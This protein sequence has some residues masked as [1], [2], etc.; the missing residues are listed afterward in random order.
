MSEMP[1]NWPGKGLESGLRPEHLYP[2]CT[3]H[4]LPFFPSFI[5]VD[6]YY[7]VY[8]IDGLP[9]RDDFGVLKDGDSPE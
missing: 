8:K 4:F 5:M 7:T 2:D 3:W 6:E 9:G 1:P